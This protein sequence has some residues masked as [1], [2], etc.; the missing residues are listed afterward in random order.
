MSG[1]VH[2]LSAHLGWKPE[3]YTYRHV[4]EHVVVLVVLGHAGLKM[5]PCSAPA[6][7]MALVGVLRGKNICILARGLYTC[8]IQ[9]DHPSTDERWS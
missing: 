5:R 2:S 6:L 7:S 8:C 3:S 4:L 1:E 9:G